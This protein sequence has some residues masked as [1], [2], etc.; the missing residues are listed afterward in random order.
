MILFSDL[1]IPDPCKAPLGTTVS[2]RMNNTEFRVNAVGRFECPRCQTR[3]Y[4]NSGDLRRHL[5]YECGIEGKFS[6]PVCTRKFQR[7]TVLQRHLNVVHYKLS[8][9]SAKSTSRKKRSIIEMK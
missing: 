9:R 4:A 5:R 6:C 3:S 2:N 8:H 1:L 7:R